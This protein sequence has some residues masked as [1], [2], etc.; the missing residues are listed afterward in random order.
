[1]RRIDRRDFEPI[2]FGSEER[3]N[4]PMEIWSERVEGTFNSIAEG[5]IN[6]LFTPITSSM[7]RRRRLIQWGWVLVFLL[8]GYLVFVFFLNSGR[9]PF[10]IQDWPKEWQY[11]TILKQALTEGI[12]PLHFSPATITPDR[13]LAL[14]ETVLSPQIFLLKFLDQG[15]FV[16][17]NT[18]FLYSIGFLGCILIGQRYRMSPFIFGI[19]VL[20]FG[21]NGH[22]MTHL[23]V[24]HSM[25]LGY[26]FLPFFFILLF[27]LSENDQGTNWS[28]WMALVL[29]GIVLQGS[30]HIFVW[31]VFFLI[32]LWLFS[33]QHRS[34]IFYALVVA[35][36]LSAFRLFPAGLQYGS[37][38]HAFFP[39]YLSLTDALRGLL[40]DVSPY[41]AIV[42][43]PSGWWEL[44]MFIGLSGLA[45]ILFFTVYPFINTS[46]GVDVLRKYTPLFIPA[47]VFALFSFGYLY[48]P[49]QSLPIPFLSLE[50]VP[51]RFMIMPIVM[52]I[53]MAGISAQDWLMRRQQ[54]LKERIVFVAFLVVL[55]QDLL[56]HAR[57]WR[58]ENLARALPY[59]EW[60]LVENIGIANYSDP[61][62]TTV[63]G[64]SIAITVIAIVVILITVLSQRRGRR[65]LGTSV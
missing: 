36:F 8:T 33:N 53:F 43:R 59:P 44:D 13:F 11:Y 28:I 6:P 18:L 38:S 5:L 26:Y 64:V 12:I 47:G 56:Q 63:L 21:F 24:G 55:I 52:L 50:R 65:K 10:E 41:E 9:I 31:C 45:F 17:V 19:M 32:L 7:S 46:Q 20:L 60:T 27:R 62:Y 42:G 54:S 25:W 22:I 57:M 2:E 34:E 14:P 49:I 23:S 58:L 37:S 29:F 30:I 35:F 48:L 4:N 39:G 51:S 61:I 1:M 16:L 3:F 15:Q 40:A